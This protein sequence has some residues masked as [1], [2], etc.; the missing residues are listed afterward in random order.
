M[1]DIILKYRQ[2]VK[3]RDWEQFHAPKNLAAALS[4]EASELLE[5][6]MW[7]SEAQSLNPTPERRQQIREEMAD[8]FLY[9]LRMAD[10]LNIDLLEATREKF[11]KVEQKYPIDKSRELTRKIKS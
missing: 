9:L 7:L 3:D 10:V 6:F 8:V 4:V 5:I 1:Q 11:V 2:F